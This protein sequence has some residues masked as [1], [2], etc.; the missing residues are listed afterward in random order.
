MPIT[1]KR[2]PFFDHIAELRRRIVIIAVTILTLSMVLY[3]WGWQIYDFVMAPVLP[4]LTSLPTIFTPFGTFGLRFQVAFY[5][6]IVV[7]APIIIWQVM[8]FFLPA[9]KPRERR[10]VVPTISAA[11]ALFILGVAFCYEIILSLGFKWILA[12]GGTSVA[13]IP[14]AQKFFQGVALLMIGFGIGFEL[15]IVVFY[16]VI[17]NIVPYAKLRSQ[18]RVVYVVLMLVASAATPDWSPWTMGG[19]FVALGVLYELS[20]LLARVTLRKRIAA[21]KARDRELYGD[22]DEADAVEPA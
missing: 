16:L 21:Q 1:P 3:T 11:V 7:G 8:A 19:L 14:D 9:L 18:W 4:Q 15:P 20:M 13:V 12:Q 2:M 10:Y 17:F 22:D 6:S 5:A